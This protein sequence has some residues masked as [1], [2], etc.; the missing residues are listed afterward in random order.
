MMVPQ[1]SIVIRELFLQGAWLEVGGAAQL[2]ETFQLLAVFEKD[3]KRRW[4]RIAWRQPGEVG[5]TF[6]DQ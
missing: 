5:V 6:L 4:C 3:P 1:S 2:P